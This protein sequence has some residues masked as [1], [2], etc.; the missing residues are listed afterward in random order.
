M[1]YI[2]VSYTLWLVFLGVLILVVSFH[3]TFT[4][5]TLVHILQ[6]DFQNS[7]NLER[8]HTVFNFVVGKNLG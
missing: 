1:L 8:Q 6:N 7:N 2:H 5:A 4:V 3:C